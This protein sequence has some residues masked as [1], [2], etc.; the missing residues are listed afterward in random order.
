MH[1]PQVKLE[2]SANLQENMLLEVNGLKTYFQMEKGKVAKAVDNVSFSINK[3]ETV[4]LVGESGS[5]KSITSLSIMRLIPKPPGEIVEGSIFLE[6][7]ELLTLPED[8]MANVRGNDIGMIFQEPMTSLDPVFTIGNQ[9]VESL[10]RH[11]KIKKSEAY[12][13]AIEL[14]KIVGFSR[15]EVIINEYPH[16]LSGGMRQRVMIAIAMS[17]NPKLLIADEPTTALD[18]TVQAQILNLMM[19][20][21]KKY[22]SSILLITHDMGVVAEV[23]DRVLVMYA[24]QIVE[25]ALVKDLF[26]KTKHPYTKALLKTIPNIEV[27]LHR[28]DSIPGTVPPAHLF[29]K[30]CRFAERCTYAMAKCHEEDPSLIENS[31]DHKVRCHL[32]EREGGM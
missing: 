11:Q 3:G 1:S 24:G 5:G 19:D 29:P 12:E 4:A 25:E 21:K 13:K 23:A 28:L 26:L 30:G 20:M 15:A 7:K 27:E 17:N 32:Y 6:G 14:L 16:Q 31:P 9:I 18:V 10:M 8:E 2:S 22:G